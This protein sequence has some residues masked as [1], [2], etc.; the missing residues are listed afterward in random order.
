MSDTHLDQPIDT[1]LIIL[2]VAKSPV[3]HIRLTKRSTISTAA[4]RVGPENRISRLRKSLQWIDGS[5][6]GEVL[7][8]NAGRTPMYVKNQWVL[9]SFDIVDRISHQPL[10]LLAV[11]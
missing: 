9:S 5:G 6:C 3:V 11:F 4:A 7:H 1:C 2:V 10:D 8:E